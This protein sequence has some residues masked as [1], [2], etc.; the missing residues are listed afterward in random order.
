MKHNWVYCGND[1]WGRMVYV[2][3]NPGCFYF[4]HYEY[5]LDRKLNPDIPFSLKRIEYLFNQHDIGDEGT[6]EGG[7]AFRKGQKAPD[8][9]FHG[10]EQHYKEGTWEII[11]EVS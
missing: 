11:G 1:D 5:D 10:L 4:R 8:C 7:S 2:C 3:S 9:P 6:W